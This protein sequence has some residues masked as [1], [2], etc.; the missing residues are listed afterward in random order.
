MKSSNLKVGPVTID[1]S[2][3]G[4]GYETF[5]IEVAPSQVVNPPAVQY[6][7]GLVNGERITKQTVGAKAAEVVNHVL[8][9]TQRAKPY[10]L[11]VK[12]IS[13]LRKKVTALLL[14]QLASTR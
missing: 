8:Y 10:S 12:Y 2:W 6:F 5:K 4:D 9:V 14:K 13:E 1:F 3:S 11:Q 7:S